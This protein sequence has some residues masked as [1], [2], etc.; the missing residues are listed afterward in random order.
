[1]S[2]AALRLDGQ[3]AL[4]GG[5]GRGNGRGCAVALAEAGAEVIA[6]TRTEAELDSL[7]AESAAAGGR[8]R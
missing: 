4:D 5:A 7:V 6:L 3:V 1:M 2:L 8:A